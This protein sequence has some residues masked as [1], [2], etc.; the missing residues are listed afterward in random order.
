MDLK[1]E[2]PC[3]LAPVSAPAR[4]SGPRAARGRDC[5]AAP[6]P[7]EH[8]VPEPA[9]SPEASQVLAMGSERF[10]CETLTT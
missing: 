7:A 5:V 1:T 4:G 10:N 3:T 8:P 2:A 6:A 9:C